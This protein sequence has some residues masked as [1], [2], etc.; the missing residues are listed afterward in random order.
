M[1][2]GQ[3]REGEICDAVIGCCNPNEGFCG[4]AAGWFN[5]VW[6]PGLNAFVSV[7][8][9]LSNTGTTVGAAVLMLILVSACLLGA[10]LYY[11]R[12]YHKEKDPDLPTV[13]Y[14]RRRLPISRCFMQV[15]PRQDL[16]VCR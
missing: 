15:P 12:K 3:C 9:K 13:T 14:V 8:E 10:V 5:A 16:H 7:A 6:R 4:K 11:R 2:C 1:Q